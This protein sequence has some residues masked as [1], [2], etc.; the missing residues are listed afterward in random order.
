MG[1][2]SDLS[3][4]R[5]TTVFQLRELLAASD[6]TGSTKVED[7]GVGRS[8]LTPRQ[9]VVALPDDL[10]LTEAF[11]SLDVC[12]PPPPSAPT[13]AAVPVAAPPAEA[14]A[15]VP[16]AQEGGGQLTD[17]GG[18]R[19]QWEVVGGVDKGGIMVRE[20]CD[21]KS[22]AASDRLATGS[23]VEELELVGERLHYRLVTGKGPDKGWV[24]LRI[25]GKDL[26]VRE[27]AAKKGQEE[28]P[29]TWQ[30]PSGREQSA[31]QILKAIG[32]PRD[33][34]GLAPDAGSGSIRRAYHCLCLLHHP[35]KGGDEVVFKA[36]SDAYKALTEA[37]DKETGGW[38]DL[39]GQAVG[40]WPAHARN[41]KG[42]TCMLFDCF[43]APPWESRRLYSG[44]WQESSVRCWELSKG[45]PGK[46]RPPPR[47]VGEIQ[48][49]GFV[50]DIAAISPFGMLTAQSAG[51]KPL[52]GESL[53]VWNLKKTPFKE[54][55]KNNLSMIKD[56]DGAAAIADGDAEGNAGAIEVAKRSNGAS[57]LA[58]REEGPDG[59]K[60]LPDTDEM[61][62]PNSGMLDDMSQMVFLHHRGVRSLSLWPRPENRDATPHLVGTVSK[63]MLAISKVSI[64]GCSLETPALWTQEN[65]HILTDVNALKH[66][67]I[68][69][70]WSGD[71]KGI[72]KCWDVNSAAKK[73]VC[74]ISTHSGWLTSMEI[75]GGPGVMLCSH[76]NG[77]AYVDTKANKMIR[78]Q[79]T[80][81]PVGRVAILNPESPVVFAGI[82]PELMQYDT[83][84]FADGN[85]VKPKAIGQWTLSANITALH[86]ISSRK[87]HL[88][89]GVG[90][91]DGKVAAFDTS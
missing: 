89:I 8:P 23:M 65:P 69:R 40:P 18:K 17:L 85:D 12:E 36:V 9:K 16:P 91:L 24:S 10:V 53:R 58:L 54:P 15:V 4:K 79:V 31:A 19:Q 41:T 70:L 25:G 28:A 32:R 43:G 49:G 66:E 6:P 77:I 62:I 20:G 73:E 48:V 80:K 78:Q 37:R 63:D 60:G 61:H 86:C 47:L 68:N 1:F 64:D 35:D 5:G 71:N 46:V 51:M 84:C 59:E 67:S 7:I 21:L 38:R 34:L 75:F 90:C 72:V 76:S 29:D 45:E 88:L 2:S 87:G 30:P 14:A 50:N 22:P 44:S 74:E 42:V 33:V 52:P 11:S 27:G 81:N 3:V 56:A 26:L 57:D 82:G 83:R 39:E 55:K 13:A